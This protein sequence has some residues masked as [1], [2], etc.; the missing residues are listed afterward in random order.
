MITVMIALFFWKL[1]FLFVFTFTHSPL[2][3]LW[4]LFDTIFTWICFKIAVFTLR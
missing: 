2:T 4:N 3:S 1:L